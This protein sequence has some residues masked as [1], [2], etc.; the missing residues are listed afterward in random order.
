[1]ARRSLFAL[2]CQPRMIDDDYGAVGG[3]RI[4]SGNG[5]TRKRTCPSV[6]HKSHMIWP[7]IEP[8]PP[9]WEESF[10][11]FCD[12]SLFRSYW[13]S[14]FLLFLYFILPT[15]YFIP[16]FSSFLLL[17]FYLS[18]LL[19]I[20]SLSAFLFYSPFILRTSCIMA[21]LCM[22]RLDDCTYRVMTDVQIVM[23]SV[24]SSG[25]EGLRPILN[26]FPEIFLDE[27]KKI[28]QKYSRTH[29]VLVMCT[30][31]VTAESLKRS[32]SPRTF[33]ALF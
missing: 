16:Y 6:Y 14:F 26:Y 25:C 32:I 18:F 12:C 27:L 29:C 15:L 9:R 13:F 21:P 31:F 24:C 5:S 33:K 10:F 19:F 2:L 23:A 22:H 4:G 30:G 8:G 28:V 20:L 1:L 17:C 11:L 3:M 7:G